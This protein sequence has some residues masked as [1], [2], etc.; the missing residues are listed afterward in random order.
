MGII[1]FIS[2]SFFFVKL[3]IIIIYYN[4]NKEGK[5]HKPERKYYEK[6]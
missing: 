4:L 5:L 2:I 6:I 3:K 1:N